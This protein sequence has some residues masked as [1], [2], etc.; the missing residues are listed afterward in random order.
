MLIRQATINLSAN[1]LSALLGL[2]SVFVFTRLFSAHDYGIYLL[3]VGFA[4]VI[5]V[6]FIGWFR[7]LILSEHAKDDGTDIRGLV[8]SGYFIACLAAPVAYGLGRLVGL[9]AWAAVAAVGLAVAIGLFELTQDLVRARLLAVTAM[10]ATLVRAVS[11]LCLG[12]VFTLI[13]TTG[14]V[15]L[16]SSGLAYLVAT[17]IQA[18]VAWR[19]TIVKFDG[20]ALLAAAKLGLPLTLSLTLLAISSVTD[21]FMIANLVGAADAGKYIA[22]LDLVRQTLMMPAISIAAAF[23]PLAVQ[24]YA[25]QGRAALRSHLSECAELLLSITLPAC[26]GFAVI[27]THVANV[28]LGVDFR[29]TAAAVMPIIAVAVV[30]QILTQQYLHVSFLL[31]GRNS[32]YLINTVSIIAVNVILSYVLIEKYGVVGAAWARLGA[33]VFGF[34]CALVLSH[35]AF[36]VP[37]PLGRLALTMIAGLMMALLVGALDRNLHVSDLGA[38][39][40]LV[41]AGFTSYAALCWAFDISQVRGRLK[42]GLTFFRA[43]LANMGIG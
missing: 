5:S 28:V 34:V 40:V 25:S 7:N 10:K 22:G 38:C 11:V 33:D 20:P 17:L 8:I 43:K 31:S 30:F 23:F 26:L 3:G 14:F 2:L 29:E 6:A 35:R 21:R 1:V 37:I 13:D 42:N 16:A 24:V 18:R 27:S 19:G 36:P 32:F 9:D 41:V 4:S 39:V 15:L 12:V